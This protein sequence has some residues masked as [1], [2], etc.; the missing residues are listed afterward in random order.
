MRGYGR[1]RF[2]GGDTGDRWSENFYGRAYSRGNSNRGGYSH[3]GW[4]GGAGHVAGGGGATSR[5]ALVYVEASHIHSR[6]LK[7]VYT[8]ANA[9]CRLGEKR[10]SGVSTV[11]GVLQGRLHRAAAEL[12]HAAVG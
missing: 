11:A 3:G 9:A 2:Y 8:R 6:K 1:A 12:L 4:G 7:P 5:S 10:S